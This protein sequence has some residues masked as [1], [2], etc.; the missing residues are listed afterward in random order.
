MNSWK[1]F[2]SLLI[3]AQLLSGCGHVK[4]SDKEGC[5]DAGDVGAACTTTLSAK[6]RWIG[7][8]EWDVI[9]YGW[10]CFS[11]E[12]FAGWKR[13]LQQACESLG[14][15]DYEKIKTTFEAIDYLQSITPREPPPVVESR[16]GT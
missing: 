5:A 10:V 1:S 14:K 3:C 2:L 12:D 4:I 11:P 15:C 6:K 7:K 8:L 9:R 13:E 16:L